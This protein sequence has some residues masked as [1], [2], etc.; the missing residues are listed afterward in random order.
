MESGGRFS[1]QLAQKV[2]GIF[3]IQR[4]RGVAAPQVHPHPAPDLQVQVGIVLPMSRSGGAQS[5]SPGNDRALPDIDGVEMS[6]ESL[7]KISLLTPVLED[8]DIAPAPCGVP[9]KQNQAVR[10]GKD[11]IPQVG[12]LSTDAV[13]IIPQVIHLTKRTGIVGQGTGFAAQRKIGGRYHG[14]PAEH[15]G[16]WDGQAASD[17]FRSQRGA[18]GQEEAVPLRAIFLG[19]R[20]RI[21]RQASE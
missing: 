19:G 7:K 21:L 8:D 3:P 11:G 10:G 2:F 18:P 5:P 14:N 20:R 13:Q 12:V 16:V 1:P 15:G 4:K 9:G 6:V 17:Q